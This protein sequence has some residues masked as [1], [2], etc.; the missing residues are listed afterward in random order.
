MSDPPQPLP[1]PPRPDPRGKPRRRG[2]IFTLLAVLGA[3]LFKG[4]GI[5]LFLLTKAKL[6][7][8]LKYLGVL[9]KSGGSMFLMIWV[10]AQL[11]PVEFAVGAVLLLLVHELGHALV[12]LH[13]GVKFSAPLF[14]PFLGALIA[15]KEMPKD[16]GKEALMAFGGPFLGTVGA[17]LCFNLYYWTGKTVFLGL[18]QF[19]YLINLFNLAPYSPLD[20]GRIVGAISPKIWIGALPLMFIAGIY[21]RSFILLLVAAVGVPRA[22]KA[23]RAT[24]EEQDYYKVSTRGRIIAATAYLGLAGFIAYMMYHAGKIFSTVS[25]G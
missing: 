13:M 3:L 15:M 16:V 8:S 10:Y 1:P 25:G 18:A 21:L 7:F 20:G 2:G 23:W 4:K 14:I 22:I 12:L 9:L 5:L 17:Q 19:G 11:W 24:P 6:L